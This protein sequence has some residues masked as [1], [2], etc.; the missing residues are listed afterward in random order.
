MKPQEITDKV[1]RFS[2]KQQQLLPEQTR[3]KVGGNMTRLVGRRNN[4]QNSKLFEP[5]IFFSNLLHTLSLLVE[6]IELGHEPVTLLI[7]GKL[8]TTGLKDHQAGVWYLQERVSHLA[9]LLP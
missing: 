1:Q 9:Y 8:N 5:C 4:F 6:R 7:E 3:N 2:L